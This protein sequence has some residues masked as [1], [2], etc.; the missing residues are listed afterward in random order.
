MLPR[1][2]VVAGNGGPDG[3]GDDGQD[4]P[5]AMPETAQAPPPPRYDRPDDA[6]RAAALTLAADNTDCAILVTAATSEIRYA[7]AGFTRMFGYAEQDVVGKRPSEVLAQ[8]HS[9]RDEVDR[10]RLHADGLK[11][12]QSELLLYRKDGTPLWVSVVF[13]PIRGEDGAV[14]YCVSTLTEI[15]QAKMHEVL[16]KDALTA[17]MRDEPLADVMDMICRELERIAP[18]LLASMITLDGAGCLHV[19]A[20]PS[21]PPE[22]SHY[23]EGLKAGPGAGACGTAA[24]QGQTVIV[25]DTRTDPLFKDF[26]FVA[27]TYGLHACWSSP[28]KSNGGNV[29]G[30]FAFYYRQPRAPDP[31]HIRLAEI[32]LHLCSLA[33]QRDQ[34]RNRIHKLA[35][36]DALTG[37]PNRMMFSA[38]AEQLMVNAELRRQSM[39][40]LFID[41]DRFKRVNETQGHA[42]GDGLLR[43]VAK[44]IGQT[45]NANDLVGRQAGNEFVVALPECAAEQAAG[46]AERLLGAIAQQAIVGRVA[47]QPSASI[48]VAMFPGDG[49][50]IDT[51]IRHADL[52]MHRTKDSGGGNFCF[53]SAEM[54]RLAQE[55]LALEA[56]LR[57]ALRRD[58]LELHYQPQLASTSPHSLLGVEALLRWTHP[59]LGSISPGRFIPMAEECGL[60]GELGRWVLSR[61]CRQMG[62]WRARGVQ[63]PKI[64]INLSAIN[65]E[66]PDLPAQLQA[67]LTEH[68]L[69][70]SDLVLEMTESVMLSPQ[71]T[72]L[73]N[74]ESIQAAGISLSLD[75]FG[76]GYSSLSHL[77]RLPIDELKLDMSFIRDLERS[78]A[79]R[80]LTN[81][82]LRIGESLGKRVVAEGVETQ[83][84]CKLLAGLGCEVLQGFLFS[85]PL[86]ADTL[87]LWIES[88][89]A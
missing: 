27:E 6:L 28:I 54:N 86:P 39:A 84:Q 76:T 12:T 45:L 7:N 65:F 30:T 57:D 29:L 42:A 26:R 44:R 11:P 40:V 53:F 32:C 3:P 51:L 37:L 4:M 64:S 71:S 21:L 70:P 50:D 56:A 5:L 60:I 34:T 15:T 35:F 75:D 87:E 20:A 82:I 73:G 48:G 17:L 2:P 58:Q 55:R 10:L 33:L 83:G 31:W 23:I 81:S 18:S 80:T 68:Q 67:L 8:S 43:D 38:R 52:A 22:Y 19:Q 25:H 24:W 47:V 41:L 13:N 74:L 61:A 85:R 16:H 9:N 14:A 66:D 62:D 49:H 36:Y 59:Q 78:A 89:R 77:H 1:A 69:S 63:V 79:A 88:R 46:M 72:V